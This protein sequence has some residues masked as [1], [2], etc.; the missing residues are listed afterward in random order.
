MTGKKPNKKE[1]DNQEHMIQQLTVQ[2]SQFQEYIDRLEKSLMDLEALKVTVEE[3]AKLKKGVA[4]HAPVANGIFVEATLE[5]SKHLLV[6]VGE[7]I[8]LKKTIPQTIKLLEKQEKE[9][10]KAKDEVEVKIQEFYSTL[11]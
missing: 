1:L 3:V 4:I 10:Q 5:D 8:V 11:G 7:G 9:I 6:N 2:A